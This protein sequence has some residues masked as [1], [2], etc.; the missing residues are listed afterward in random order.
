[1]K[2]LPTA[3][4]AVASQVV[5]RMMAYDAPIHSVYLLKPSEDIVIHTSDAGEIQLYVNDGLAL[6]VPEFPADAIRRCTLP[7]AGREPRAVIFADPY[8]DFDYQDVPDQDDDV[9]R[10]FASFD[11]IQILSGVVAGYRGPLTWWWRV[12]ENAGR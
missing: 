3:A 11:I 9:C 6:C 1:M 5:Y 2:T 4:V 8:W 7:I 10:D 12:L